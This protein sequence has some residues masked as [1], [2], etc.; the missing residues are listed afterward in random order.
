MYA[1]LY[2]GLEDLRLLVSGG[3]PGPSPL[4]V[5]RDKCGDSPA[6]RMSLLHVKPKILPGLLQ[7][8]LVDPWPI[9]L[10]TYLFAF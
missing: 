3:C 10:L 8:T 2:G 7:S 4:R 6:H 9:S 5:Q 1:I